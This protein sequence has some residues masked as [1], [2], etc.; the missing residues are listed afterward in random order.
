MIS[1]SWWKD[2][3]ASKH[4]GYRHRIPKRLVNR[5]GLRDIQRNLSP[6]LATITFPIIFYS[7]FTQSMLLSL[8]LHS[9]RA[10]FI[11]PATALLFYSAF[12]LVKNELIFLLRNNNSELSFFLCWSSSL[13]L[14]CIQLLS[15]FLSSSL[16]FH[17]Q[18]NLLLRDLGHIH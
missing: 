5:T 9:S 15:I 17:G 14:P 2:H 12:S 6:A 8:S 4:A 1:G 7:S 13:C 11:S 10:L 16:V 3:R 18:Q